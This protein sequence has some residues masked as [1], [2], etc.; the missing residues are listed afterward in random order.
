MSVTTTAI[1]EVRIGERFRRDL[2]DLSS[3]A[4]S[5]NEVGLLQP[6]VV[7]ETG[8]LVAGLRRLEACRSLGWTAVPVHTV[9]L[10]EIAKGEFYE[11]VA[12]KGFTASEIVAIKRAL[13]PAVRKEAKKRQ[14]TRVDRGKTLPAESAR[15]R[16]VIAAYL[17]VSHDTLSKMEK[18][19]EAARKDPGRLGS[20][21]Q[22][23]DEGKMSLN[24]AVR[25][26]RRKENASMEPARQE[27][28]H[29]QRASTTE[30]PGN[31]MSSV[32]ETHGKAVMATELSEEAAE[33]QLKKES[34]DKPEP[35]TSFA[36]P[37]QALDV[38]SLRCPHCGA[39]STQVVWKCCQTP[40]TLEG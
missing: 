32:E 21:L 38:P 14:G 9:N 29:R 39:D 1:A 35:R 4:R 6:I 33:P 25:I 13:E 16:S 11:N 3:L 12:R 36:S 24:R 2:G 23:V 26:F 10:S 28:K 5:I 8:R 20:I 34:S 30:V 7:D 40:F 27:G 18:L 31:V 22:M 37:S 19:V 15:S 17:G